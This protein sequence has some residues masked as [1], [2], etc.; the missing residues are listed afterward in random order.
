MFEERGETCILIYGLKKMQFKD[1]LK[2]KKEA[3]KWLLK[4]G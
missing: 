4:V 3:E 2:T 1:K